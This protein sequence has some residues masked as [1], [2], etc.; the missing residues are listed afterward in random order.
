MILPS[1]K[2]K[3]VC[4]LTTEQ[5]QSKVNDLISDQQTYEQLQK[6]PTTS[7]TR[8][9]REALKTIENK[10]NLS[11]SQYLKLYPSDRSAPLFYG[12]PKVHKEGVPLRPIVSSIGSATYEISKFLVGILS[13][14]VGNTEFSVEDSNDFVQFTKTLSLADDEVMVSFDVQ[15]LFT[16]VPTDVACEVARSRL[17]SE[18]EREESIIR[19]KT[20]LDVE[21]IIL[22][23]R[24]C[25]NTTY[26]QVNGQYYAQKQ[27]T[28]MGSPISVVV[29]N[30]F[31]ENIEEKALQSFTCE[32]KVWKRYVDDTF[33]V[34]KAKDLDALHGHLNT[35]ADGVAFTVER[36]KDGCL[37]FL[38]VEVRRADDGM[39]RTGVYRKSTHTDRY[40]D[41]NS[42][43]S[44][45]HKE[46]VVRSLV[47]RGRVLPS[48]ETGRKKRS[49]IHRQ[50]SRGQQLPSAFY[51]EYPP[52]N[53]GKA[54]WG[55]KRDTRQTG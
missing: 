44:M 13:P 52:Q 45:Q 23:L 21:D 32:V 29:A 1:D 27:V 15:S 19:A 18:F 33:V 30:L 50:N 12:L 16:S 36:E 17:E 10:G 28:A 25:L 53:A 26:F 40:L 8:K 35:Q 11:R 9:V 49:K 51:P 5:Y 14:L 22:L 24:L 4:V 43:H 39:L 42:H 38:D 48:D 2:G 31:M 7:Y 6:D 20:S 54:D 3:S 47:N 34:L 37:P 55:R 46:S 41:F